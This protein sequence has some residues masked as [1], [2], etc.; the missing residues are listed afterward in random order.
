LFYLPALISSTRI[1][2]IPGDLC[3]FSFA[4]AISTSEALLDT[5]GC[6]VCFSV[7][8]TSLMP[9]IFSSWEKW[10]YHLAKILWESKQITLLIL[11]YINSR[12][13]TLLKIID[14]PLQVSDIFYLIVS[15]KLINFSYQIFPLFIPEMSNGFTS[16]VILDYLHS[17]GFNLLP[18]AF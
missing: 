4:V 3:L 18:T 8:L 9:Y 12:L 16:Y 14:A 15:F 13:V 5:V 7:C 1:W 17:F 6:A 11:Y 2:S 10:F